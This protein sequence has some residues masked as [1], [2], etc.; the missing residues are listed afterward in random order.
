MITM[1]LAVIV[2]ALIAYGAYSF[3]YRKG[4]TTSAQTTMLII[5]EFLK[6]K[7]GVDWTNITLGNNFNRLHRWM[8][9]MEN[10]EEES[11]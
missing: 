5:R 11:T 10:G 1:E 6:E 2:T 3:G 8:A 9:E 4:T 7:Q